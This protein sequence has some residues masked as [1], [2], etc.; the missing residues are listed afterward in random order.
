M[1]IE[2]DSQLLVHVITKKIGVPWGIAYEIRLIVDLLPKLGCSVCHIYG[3]GN[4]LKQLIF[5][6]MLG[7]K[8]EKRKLTFCS[9]DIPRKLFGI[10]RV[11]MASTYSWYKNS[12]SVIFFVPLIL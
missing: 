7:Y 2:V 8:L 10:T 6:L 5:L 11:D 3:E 12:K 9:S 1:D 4:K